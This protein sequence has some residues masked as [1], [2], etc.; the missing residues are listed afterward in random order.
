LP[1]Y[2][3]CC[4]EV[5]KY[6]GGQLLRTGNSSGRILAVFPTYSI[7]KLKSKKFFKGQSFCCGT[8][9]IIFSIKQTLKNKRLSR[10]NISQGKRPVV[11][12]VA[13]NPIDHPHGGGQ[14]KTSGGRPSVTP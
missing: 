2:Y 6:C 8:Y 1:G 5:Q 12:G 9:G 4:I 11:R 3:I 13:K 10:I 7:I 14:G